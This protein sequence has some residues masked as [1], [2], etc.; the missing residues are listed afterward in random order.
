[1]QYS[2]KKISVLSLTALNITAIV[3]LSSIAFMAT[4]GL[5]SVFFYLIAAVTFLVPTSLICA[6]LSSMLTNNNGGVFSWVKAG[7]GEKAGVLA[8]WLEW[9]NNVVGFPSTVTA[10]IATFAYVGFRGFVENTH[11]SFAFWLVMVAT[12]IAV[13]LFNCWPMRRVIIL[14][15]VG[16]VFGMIIPGVLLVAGAM[17]FL[18]TGQSHLEY[19]GVTDFLP[20]LSLGTYALLVKTLSSYSGIQSVAFHMTNIEN[21]EKNIPRSILLAT[22]IIVSLTI[23][24]TVSLM[25][26]VPVKDVNVLNGLIQ[27]ISAVLTIVGLGSMK[28]VIAI[29]VSIGMLAALSTWVLG[30]ARGMQTA[31][32]QEFF[33]KVMAGENKYG[34][35]TNMLMIQVAIV[36]FLSLA[37]LVMPSIYSAFALLV[38]ITSQFTVVM[39]IMVFAAA[40]RLRFKKASEHRAFYVG[41]RGTNWLLVSMSCIAIFMCVLGFILGLFP[42]AFSHVKNVFQ[43]TMILVVADVIIVAIP[44]VWIWLHR[45]RIL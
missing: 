21:P 23:L 45:K 19:H 10:L 22:V 31:A 36:V 6:E 35:P 34:M 24:T 29:M 28:P 33:P 5:Q 38:A 32:E 39:W 15:I 12:F 17:Y 42:P 14:N 27:G 40:I 16:V 13:S 41:K 8:M 2:N 44:L 9:F 37:F 18:I 4:I 26:V 20:A 7:L 30:P 43:Y 11:T 25:I 1:M 3:S